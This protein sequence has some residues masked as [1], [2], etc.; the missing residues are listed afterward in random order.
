MP[1]ALYM[2]RSSM[3]RP[4]SPP[5]QSI[6]H[7]AAGDGSRIPLSSS[8]PHLT[9]LQWSPTAFRLKSYG[10]YIL[11]LL[12]SLSHHSEPLNSYISA[13]FPTPF[14]PS[15][16]FPSLCLL[17]SPIPLSLLGFLTHSYSSFKTAQRLPLLGRLP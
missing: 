10:P 16:L 7:T 17:F 14:T 1:E 11:S 3:A 13:W 8:L 2:N 15:H 5:S 6:L 9:V 12:T 4:P